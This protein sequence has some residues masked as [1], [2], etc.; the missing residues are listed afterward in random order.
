ME[1]S[2]GY[3]EFLPAVTPFVSAGTYAILHDV[4]LDFTS[5]PADFPDVSI[6]LDSVEAYDDNHDG[7]IDGF[8]LSATISLSDVDLSVGGRNLLTLESLTLG[9]DGLTIRPELDN[10][11]RT[12]ELIFSATGVKLLPD[13]LDA[14]PLEDGVVSLALP[15][16]SDVGGIDV[17]TGALS[18]SVD[19]PGGIAE[20]L[21]MSGWLPVKLTHVDAAFD[22]AGGV[23]DIGFALAGFV[24][25]D[26][27]VSQ[28]RRR[29]R[30]A[31][32]GHCGGSVR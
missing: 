18:L 23:P 6:F 15:A 9:V 7:E 30:L 1:L 28:L 25:S 2:A 11:I 5:L 32:S 26:H 22:P 27:L 10:G 3:V 19:V 4:T 12:G 20:R 14:A 8:A 29:D 13:G 21:T 31:Q 17:A 16:P 24:D